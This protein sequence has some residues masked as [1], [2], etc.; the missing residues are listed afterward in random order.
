MGQG[1]PG[2]ERNRGM[3]K[4]KCDWAG[5]KGRDGVCA[6]IELGG[7]QGPGSDPLRPQHQRPAKTVVPRLLSSSLQGA[8]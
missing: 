4:G 8:R 5:G 6:R 2:E 3:P 1:D 7:R